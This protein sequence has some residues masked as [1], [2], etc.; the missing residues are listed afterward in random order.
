MARLRSIVAA[1]P[2][3]PAPYGLLSSAYPL[4]DPSLRGDD[5]ARWEQGFSIESEA[6]NA[7]VR[8][9]DLCDPN[10][11]AVTVVDRSDPSTV[12]RF[13]D[14]DPMVV[15]VEDHCSTFGFSAE[16]R[17]ARLGRQLEAATQFALE[18]EF[19]TGALAKDAAPDLPNRYLAMS[20]A[21]DVTPTPGT[22]VKIRQG[23]ALLEGALGSCGL[24]TVGA[25]HAPRAVA[26][27]LRPNDVDGVLRT[28][29]GNTLIAGSG[30][31]GSAP[32]GTDPTGTQ[33]W[34]YATG[35]V[36]VQLGEPYFTPDQ[37]G[38]AITTSTNDFKLMAERTAA[39]T[40]DGCCH[41][42]V[43]VDLAMDYS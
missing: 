35:P 5:A 33:R 21:T 37:P 11:T 26:S 40:W 41:F 14:Y 6:C 42:G 39:A 25:I 24:G 34:M 20:D 23:L 10:N 32:N 19:W 13:S 30:Y 4:N 28:P 12:L 3:E 22:A 18:R 38:Q 43:L 2:L 1:P 8:V 27:A 29:I 17:Y 7:T 15:Q 16:Q 36:F 31:T 9:A